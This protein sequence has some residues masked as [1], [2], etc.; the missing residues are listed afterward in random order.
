MLA[1]S[2]VATPTFGFVL[3]KANQSMYAPLAKK[4]QKR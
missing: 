3:N 1:L 4:Q 2:F